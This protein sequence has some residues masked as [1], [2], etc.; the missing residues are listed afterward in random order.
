MAARLDYSP[1]VD[2]RKATAKRSS[3]N[4]SL[5]QGVAPILEAAKYTTKATDLLKLGE[6]LPAFNSEM[7][8]LRLYGVSGKLRRHIHMQEPQG[9]DLLEASDKA[10][11]DNRFAAVVS[12]FDAIQ[13]YRFVI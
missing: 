3:D 2:I 10:G 11:N 5:G 7:K 8:H 13:E 4:G 1:I 9:N 12:W 6:L